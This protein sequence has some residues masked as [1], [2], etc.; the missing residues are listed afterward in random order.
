[1]KLGV[2]SIW[3]TS[4]AYN[5]LVK[6]LQAHSFMMDRASNEN[7]GAKARGFSDTYKTKSSAQFL[8]SHDWL[9]D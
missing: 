3:M 8:S 1:M 2:V 5:F 7:A 9:S 4:N 6:F